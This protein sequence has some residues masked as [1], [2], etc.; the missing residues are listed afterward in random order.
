MPIIHKKYVGTDFSKFKCR[1]VGLGN[2]W[3]NVQG[4]DTYASM[5]RVDTV[6]FLFA[7]GSAMDYDCFGIDV[8]EAFLTTEVNKQLP[9][10]SVLDRDPLGQTNYLRRPPGD[11][12]LEMPY[13][14]QPNAFVYGH[15]LANPEFNVDTHAL[16]IKL[17]FIPCTYDSN[18]YVLDNHLGK[19]ILAR[20]VD[21]R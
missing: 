15:P 1:M 6:K 2:H 21:N 18:V 16:I 4:V 20:A 13:I 7:V 19:A 3:K 8:I 12:G 10:R 9:K 17:G 11:T 14:S 5:V